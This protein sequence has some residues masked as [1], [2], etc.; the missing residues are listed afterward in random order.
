M[1]DPLHP[2]RFELPAERIA[3]HPPAERDGGR[4]MLLRAGG[5]SPELDG[6]FHQQVL[7]LPELLEP[8]D[9]LVVNDTRVLHARL[10]GRR[11]SG[12]QVEALLLEPGPGPVMAML[13]PGRR[14]KVGERLQMGPGSMEL[15][16]RGEGGAW[17]VRCTPEPAELMAQAGEIPLPPYFGRDPEAADLE[18]YQTTFAGEAGAVAAPTAGLHLSER[19]ISALGARGVE[20]ARVTLHVG[21]GTFRNLRPEDI[22]R[23]LLHEERYILPPET[24]EAIS[25][26]RARGGRVIAVGTTSTRTLESCA[27]GNGGVRPG[28]GSTR[29]FIRPGYR[30]QVIDGLM[31]NFHLPASSLLMLVGALV[32]RE[33]LLAAY[34]QAIGDGYRFYSYGDAMLLLPQPGA[35]LPGRALV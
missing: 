12:G 4:L 15:L 13:R 26:T 5:P 35:H 14:L 8:G 23:G 29:M 3:T 25:R 24:A 17:R 6:V 18:R 2:W 31:T 10:Y 28:E 19:L 32:G 20:L 7:D 16:E 33:R 9:L 30:F 22:E 21:A 11:Q 27:D 1:S 34:R